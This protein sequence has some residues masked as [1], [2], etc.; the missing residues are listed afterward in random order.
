MQ[1]PNVGYFIAAAL[2]QLFL[3]IFARLPRHG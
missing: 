3:L 2:C 1:S